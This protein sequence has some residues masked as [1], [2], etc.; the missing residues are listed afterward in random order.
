MPLQVLPAWLH[1]V[2]PG[3]CTPPTMV[4][5]IRLCASRTA[6][7]S[8]LVC[9]SPK[10]A[11][12]EDM[13]TQQL[14]T[15]SVP[16][17]SAGLL[18]S[19]ISLA[20]VITCLRCPLEHLKAPIR[21]PLTPCLLLTWLPLQLVGTKLMV[22]I[23][24]RAWDFAITMPPTLRLTMSLRASTMSS[25]ANTTTVAVAL[26]TA[27]PPPTAEQWEQAPWKLLTLAPPQPGE[28]AMALVCGSWPIWGGFFSRN[29]TKRKTWVLRPLLAMELQ[30]Q[31]RR[32]AAGL[33][34]GE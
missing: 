12:R 25:T 1:I 27:T 34:R 22:S 30:E 32:P 4:H 2:A 16:T 5:Y 10:R 23:S 6:R 15:P 31:P 3:R 18:P 7:L 11:I 24:C 13:L 29:T 8:T 20:R 28:A 33:R 21:V 17:L 14:R 9:S 19:M 26:T